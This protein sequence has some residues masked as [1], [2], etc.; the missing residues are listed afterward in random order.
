MDSN[1][2]FLS[3]VVS[4]LLASG[5]PLREQL[6]VV[7][8]KRSGTFLQR[9]LVAQLQCTPAT[10]LPRIVTIDEWITE[11]SGRVILDNTALVS[12][13]YE[14]YAA[15]LAKQ[16][17]EK[18]A[19]DQLLRLSQTERMLRDFQDMDL[20]LANVEMLLGNLLSLIHI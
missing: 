11:M 16:E 17:E 5:I 19:A 13:L 2:N 20:A 3:L 18:P 14:V 12:I 8:T 1:D 4:R 9:Q 7:P 10:I 6:V 15:Y